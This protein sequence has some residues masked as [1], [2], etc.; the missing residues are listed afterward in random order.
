[1]AT[2]LS[3]TFS[4]SLP[5]SLLFLIRSLIH[6]KQRC[7]ITFVKFMPQKMG[8]LICGAWNLSLCL[9]SRTQRIKIIMYFLN[10][11]NNWRAAKFSLYYVTAALVLSL[12]LDNDMGHCSGFT[13]EC[14]SLDYWC[15]VV[16]TL[17]LQLNWEHFILV[18]REQ[19]LFSL[20]Q[21]RTHHTL[22]LLS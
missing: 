7:F 18:F 15:A 8:W 4:S 3:V 13:W 19:P 21:T 2:R 1:M 12:L 22:V 20:P 14:F 16:L 6:L 5:R 17:W 10:L 9:S 11:Y